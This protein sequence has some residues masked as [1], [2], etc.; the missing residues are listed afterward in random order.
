MDE[1]SFILDLIIPENSVKE[2]TDL[3]SFIECEGSM[4]RY[5][6]EGMAIYFDRKCSVMSL[7]GSQMQW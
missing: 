4:E 1:T 3:K 7:R 5:N 6:S 2:L